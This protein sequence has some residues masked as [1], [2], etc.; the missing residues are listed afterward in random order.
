MFLI[1]LSSELSLISVGKITAKNLDS[2]LFFPIRK[3][4]LPK[5]KGEIPPSVA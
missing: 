4:N 1:L 2:K 5:V 3:G